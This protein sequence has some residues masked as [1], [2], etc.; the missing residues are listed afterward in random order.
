MYIGHL[1]S[2]VS[3]LLAAGY[4]Q[5]VPMNDRWHAH[6]LLSCF[7]SRLNLSF[8][9]F[10][11]NVL[12]SKINYQDEHVLSEWSDV[13]HPASIGLANAREG[14]RKQSGQSMVGVVA[15][16]G[17]LRFGTSHTRPP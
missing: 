2:C 3:W 5:H 17:Q 9:M 15:K 4:G 8:A 10:V 16:V 7:L 13:M 14:N 1:W 11:Y 6:P 12:D